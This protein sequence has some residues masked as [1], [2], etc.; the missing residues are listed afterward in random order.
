MLEDIAKI[1]SNT[2]TDEVQ[3]QFYSNIVHLANEVKFESVKDVK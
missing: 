2:H 3:N 1:L